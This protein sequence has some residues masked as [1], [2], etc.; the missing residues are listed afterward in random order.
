MCSDIFSDEI[1]F[2]FD[3]PDTM[4]VGRHYSSACYVKYAA[5]ATF[6][7]VLKYQDAP[8]A[9]RPHCNASPD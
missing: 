1:P 2:L 8:E 6:Y 5:P 7:L 9:G 3:F 4:A